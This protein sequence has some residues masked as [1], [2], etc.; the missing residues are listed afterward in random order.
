MTT[1][2]ETL[3]ILEAAVPAVPGKIEAVGQE[4]EAFQKSVRDLLENLGE[5]EE[6]ARGLLDRV[7]TALD[8]VGRMPEQAGTRH[9]RSRGG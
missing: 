1:L 4:A 7:R 6:Q 3:P 8:A 5:K 2:H 9:S